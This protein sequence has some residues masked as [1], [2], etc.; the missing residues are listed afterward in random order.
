MSSV[1]QHGNTRATSQGKEM[2]QGKAHDPGPFRKREYLCSSVQ[3]PR[4]DP[5]MLG[6]KLGPL[7]N[8]RQGSSY[9]TGSL[10][11]VLSGMLFFFFYL[12]LRFCASNPGNSSLDE[13]FPTV[14]EGVMCPSNEVH[15]EGKTIQLSSQSP[16]CAP[17]LFSWPFPPSYFLILR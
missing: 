5:S 1:L 17:A 15:R 4:K 14:V 2:S 7:E 11:S 8:I 16:V 13:C 6:A 10:I 3:G 12:W 9:L